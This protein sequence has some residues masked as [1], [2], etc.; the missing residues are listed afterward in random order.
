MSV[1]E[2]IDKGLNKYYLSLNKEYKNLFKEFCSENGYNDDT[3]QEELDGDWEE[4]DFLEFD[5]DMPFS[6]YFI[7]SGDEKD[8]IIFKLIKLCAENTDIEFVNGK[9]KINKPKKIQ[10][11]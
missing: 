9:P 8:E 2:N 11:K 10:N 6:K 7:E 1:L 5:D 3:L 4:C